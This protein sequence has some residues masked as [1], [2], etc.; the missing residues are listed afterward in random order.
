MSA[1]KAPKQEKLTRNETI[2]SFN[3]W[4]ENLCYVLF[5]DDNFKPFF[6]DGF[7]WGKKTR[8]HPS[9]DLTDDAT[10]VQNALTKEKKCAHVD[11][12]LGQVANYATVIS[13]NQ[14]TK[15][16]ASFAEIWNKIREH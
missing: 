8:A 11:L 16:S 12:M 5:L 3:S 4:K 13:R 15:N 10:T 6:A 1:S 14:I 2:I 7:I 9:R